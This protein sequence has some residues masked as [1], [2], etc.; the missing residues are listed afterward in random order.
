MNLLPVDHAAGSRG[1]ADFCDLFVVGH[2][3]D[4]DLDPDRGR[5]RAQHVSRR[6]AA[7]ATGPSTWTSF[8]ASSPFPN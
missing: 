5:L 6:F 8:I 7:L 2:S 1:D 4:I 3:L